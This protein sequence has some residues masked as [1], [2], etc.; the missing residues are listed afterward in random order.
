MFEKT[1]KRDF[2]SSRKAPSSTSMTPTAAVQ[3]Q[4]SSDHEGTDR[5]TDLLQWPKCAP[6]FSVSRYSRGVVARRVAFRGTV[7]PDKSVPFRSSFK[8]LLLFYLNY[9]SMRNGLL[10][11]ILQ[12][13]DL[14]SPIS[15]V[16]WAYSSVSGV[17]VTNPLPLLLPSRVSCHISDKPT[18]LLPSSP[19]RQRDMGC[20]SSG[21]VDFEMSP[22]SDLATSNMC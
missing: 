14:R 16:Q 4:S 11:V 5:K 18:F 12:I 20:L 21:R 6:A 2:S 1:Q 10:K 7:N 8:T 22:G 9:L 13:P 3:Q 17:A 19:Q 15:R